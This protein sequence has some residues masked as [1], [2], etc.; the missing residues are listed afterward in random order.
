M[1]LVEKILEQQKINEK[2]IE[3]ININQPEFD[4]HTKQLIEFNKLDEEYQ[5][6]QN[7]NRQLKNKAKENIKTLYNFINQTIE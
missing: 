1:Q 4:H 5:I 6:L 3:M 7:E 2:Y